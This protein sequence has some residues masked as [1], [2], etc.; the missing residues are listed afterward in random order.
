ME[1]SL[2]IHTEVPIQLTLLGFSSPLINVDDIPL[3]VESIVFIV[4]NDISVLMINSALDIDSLSSLVD[5]VLSSVSEELPP[6]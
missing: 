5:E 2:Y 3:L 1:W 4:N 6:S